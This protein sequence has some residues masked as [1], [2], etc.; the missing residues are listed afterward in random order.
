MSVHMKHSTCP[1]IISAHT[2]GLPKAYRKGPL[3]GLHKQLLPCG[4]YEDQKV[5]LLKS[6]RKSLDVQ[7]TSDG[8]RGSFQRPA[9]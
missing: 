3:K 7:C 1:S 5:D 2:V 6:L 9:G 8:G 4:E